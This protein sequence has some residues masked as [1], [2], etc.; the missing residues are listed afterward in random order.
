MAVYYKELL[1]C[2]V[3]PPHMASPEQERGFI[4]LSV[5]LKDHSHSMV[6]LLLFLLGDVL[7]CTTENYH[8]LDPWFTVGIDGKLDSCLTFLHPRSTYR[9]TPNCFAALVSV[10][11]AAVEVEWHWCLVHVC[12]AAEWE[13]TS[14]ADA[15]MKGQDKLRFAIR[16]LLCA[17]GG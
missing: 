2:N 13:L 6:I 12:N 8:W 4:T 3:T 7:A 11:F 14:L 1:G 15:A 5:L 9:S 16:L 17:I 10:Y